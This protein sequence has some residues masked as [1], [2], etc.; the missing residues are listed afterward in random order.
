MNTPD[1]RTAVQDVRRKAV[2]TPLDMLILNPSEAFTLLDRISQLESTL[3]QVANYVHRCAP[4]DLVEAGEDFAVI[5][6]MA[7]T[8]LLPPY[9]D[10]DI[11]VL[12]GS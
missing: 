8:P 5:R 4:G 7:M 9:T 2:T 1:L 10:E 3:R 12:T 6:E 11:G